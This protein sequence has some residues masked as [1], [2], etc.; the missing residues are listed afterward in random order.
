MFKFP[1]NIFGIALNPSFEC[2]LG[3][4][5]RNQHSVAEAL[6]KKNRA[7]VAIADKHGNEPLWTAAFNARGNYETVS[8]LRR[9][10]ANPGHRNNAGLSPRDVAKRMSEDALVRILES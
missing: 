2:A 10:G 6:V 7:V 3:Y 8:M 5:L 1:D 9:F 4:F